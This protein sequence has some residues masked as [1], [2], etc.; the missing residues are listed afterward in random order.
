META[1]D[2][3]MTRVQA[4]EAIALAIQTEKAAAHDNT[5]F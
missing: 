2:M 5:D 4:G 1:Q 3:E